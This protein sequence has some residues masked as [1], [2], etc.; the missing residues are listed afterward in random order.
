MPTAHRLDKNIK[1]LATTDQREL[2]DDAA[3]RLGMTR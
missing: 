2:I 3:R 1:V